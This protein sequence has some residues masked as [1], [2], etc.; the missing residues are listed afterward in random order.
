MSQRG[1]SEMSVDFSPILLEVNLLGV[2]GRPSSMM[3]AGTPC[4]PVAIIQPLLLVYPDRYS[5]AIPA[6]REPNVRNN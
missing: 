5:F 4:M 1:E 3:T 2:N 6:M